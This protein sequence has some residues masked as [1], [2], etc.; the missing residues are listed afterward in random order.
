MS[1]TRRIKYF[2]VHTLLL[3]NRQAGELIA[4]LKVEVNGKVIGDNCLIDE[5]SEIKVNDLVVKEKT[6]FVYLKFNKPAGYECSLNPAVE[7]NLSAFFLQYPRL[8]IAG[9]L[10]KASKGLLLLSNDGKWVEKLCHPRFEKEKE[11]LVTLDK[12]PSEEHLKQFRS[13]VRLGSGMSLPC[14]CDI[15]E[16]ATLTIVLKEGKNRQ[17]RRMWH[18]L[19][20]KVTELQRTR[21]SNW[22]LKTLAEGKIEEFNIGLH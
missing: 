6:K 2:L 10:D 21:I 3:S 1:F 9:R 19:G 5:Q 11:Y 17:I 13:G 15:V 18:H 8:S 7:N 16:G 20:L 14:K 22:E 12:V 4:S